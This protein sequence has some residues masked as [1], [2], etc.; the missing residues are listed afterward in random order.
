[1][2]GPKRDCA[3]KVGTRAA[4]GSRYEKAESPKDTKSAPRVLL[5]QADALRQ[6]A[7][8]DR[9]KGSSWVDLRQA[10]AQVVYEMC[11]VA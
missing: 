10:A 7:I 4:R 8:A 1:M 6:A 3:A 9:R 11:G 2:T 5:E